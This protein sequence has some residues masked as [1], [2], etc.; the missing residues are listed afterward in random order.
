MQ[1]KFDKLEFVQY[2]HFE[3]IDWFKKNGTKYLLNSDDSCEEICNSKAFVDIAGKHGG[4]C[5]IYIELN[6][7]HQSKI[8]RDPELQNKQIVLSK[9]PLDVMQVS[10]QNAQ[11]GLRSELIDWYRDATSVP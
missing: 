4:L 2:V 9:S 3:N 10:T 11:L 5:T 8:G 6:L 1:K 7:F